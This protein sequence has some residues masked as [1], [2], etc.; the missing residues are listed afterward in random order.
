[1]TR[2]SLVSV[3]WSLFSVLWSRFFLPAPC[4]FSRFSFAP[5]SLKSTSCC[6][7]VTQPSSAYPFQGEL[8]SPRTLFVARVPPSHRRTGML[9]GKR[10]LSEDWRLV[11]RVQAGQVVP[12]FLNRL[13]RSCRSA[14]QAFLG[15]FPGICCSCRCGPHRI[16]PGLPAQPAQRWTGNGPGIQCSLPRRQAATPLQEHSASQP[17]ACSLSAYPPSLARACG[18]R[19]RDIHGPAQLHDRCRPR[20]FCSPST[21]PPS[22]PSPL[23][24]CALCLSRRG[25]LACDLS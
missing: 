17:S 22:A 13:W 21:T 6:C 20:L 4:S 1:M 25:C 2:S 23:P 8:R 7:H 18:P 16:L 9:V 14:T 24:C 19:R 11:P 3:R 15:C 5:P 10:L 12:S